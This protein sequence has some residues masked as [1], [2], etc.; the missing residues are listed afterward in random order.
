MSDRGN[1][2]P[3]LSGYPDDDD[4]E[5]D[6]VEAV[7]NTG[8]FLWRL[9]E[10]RLV[11]TAFDFQ[12]AGQYTAGLSTGLRVLSNKLTVFAGVHTLATSDDPVE[13]TK[14]AVSTVGG[15]AGLGSGLA[16]STGAARLAGTLGA[17]GASAGWIGTAIEVLTGGGRDILRGKEIARADGAALGYA[18][19]L[20]GAVLGWTEQEVLRQPGL[21]DE[22]S[23][24][25]ERARHEGIVDGVREGFGAG[26]ALD[27]GEREAFQRMM[28]SHAQGRVPP[29]SS[30]NEEGTAKWHQTWLQWNA[31]LICS[32][33]QHPP[34]PPVPPA[35]RVPIAS[36]GSEAPD[37]DF[38]GLVDQVAAEVLQQ[39]DDGGDADDDV[40]DTT[41][42]A[43]NDATDDSA[44]D[45]D[46]DRPTGGDGGAGPTDPGG[47]TDDEPEDAN[48]GPSG[49]SGAE[50]SDDRPQP[51][52]LGAMVRIAAA[53]GDSVVGAV[54][55]LADVAD[56][57]FDAE[58][59][60]ED[61]PMPDDEPDRDED[62]DLELPGDDAGGGRADLPLPDDDG[63]DVD[64]GNDL[65][66]DV[67][68]DVNPNS[69]G[70]LG[71]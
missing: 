11:R 52:A 55:H 48:G 45:E 42:D 20:A 34:D 68:I 2:A 21:I 44:G 19:G 63:A 23:H 32:L 70:G 54:S 66:L 60:D 22:L 3:I 58:D 18:Y 37:V 14:G 13:L 33:I 57:L 47:G 41:D 4:D 30:T 1:A 36:G 9:S 67:D 24:G 27:E 17:V 29:F 10:D 50:A 39:L 6:Q 7:Q 28:W 53:V 46:D 16:S 51:D 64:D 26:A 15:A 69:I 8:L 35:E 31:H 49:R 71:P 43:T 56:D 12:W 5:V 62:D 65:E 59:G 25:G 61:L 38:W 40:P